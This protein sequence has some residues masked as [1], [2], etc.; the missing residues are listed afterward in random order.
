[1]GHVR[2]FLVI[3]LVFV[4]VLDLGSRRFATVVSECT[5]PNIRRKNED[6]GDDEDGKE[7]R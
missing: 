4:V 5:W 6:E 2:V 3:V 1:L 7:R